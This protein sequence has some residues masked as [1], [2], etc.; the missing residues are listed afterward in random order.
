EVRLQGGDL[1]AARAATA[2]AAALLSASD[3]H[4]AVEI[5]DIQ[6]RIALADGDLDG[7]W[8]AYRRLADVAQTAQLRYYRRRAL[9]GRAEIL[10]I[11]GDL[12]G[13]QATYEEAEELV[14]NDS[15][16]APLGEGR[17]G[18]LEQV[19]IGSERHV[20]L[21]LERPDGAALAAAVARRS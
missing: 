12:D 7:A 14:A 8:D 18:F 4:G 20:A 5:I 10:E 17:L 19:A 6:A 9:L 11:R 1:D 3:R 15:L 16:L 21:L 13:A 2:A